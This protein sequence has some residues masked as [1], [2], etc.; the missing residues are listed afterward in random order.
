MFFIVR[1]FSASFMSLYLHTACTE[2][3]SSCGEIQRDKTATVKNVDRKSK[4]RASWGH[5][6]SDWANLRSM[7]SNWTCSLFHCRL[8]WLQ[9]FE[10]STQIIICNAVRWWQITF[11]RQYN[12]QW[13]NMNS[14]IR[15]IWL[16][17]KW[18]SAWRFGSCQTAY[19]ITQIFF[20][21]FL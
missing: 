11:C 16:D 19:K 6:I 20:L 18:W 13:K 1:G 10:I 21:S 8:Y 14:E 12:R 2:H 15:P 3:F 5:C 4:V 7:L 9:N 17:G